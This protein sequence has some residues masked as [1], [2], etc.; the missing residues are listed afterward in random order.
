MVRSELTTEALIN[1]Y[2]EP[3]PWG[4]GRH[5]AKLKPYWVSVWVLVNR[6]NT[7]TSVSELAREYNV[8]EE[9]V[10]A[11]Q[12]FY[13]QNRAVIDAWILINESMFEDG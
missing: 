5:A 3:N 1:R 4:R 13:E 6:L 9:A 8:P 2:I 12:A 11:A 10:E 7:G